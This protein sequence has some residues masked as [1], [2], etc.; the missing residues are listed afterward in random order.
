ML[1]SSSVAYFRFEGLVSKFAQV[2]VLHGFLWSLNALRRRPP[3]PLLI[4]R[5]AVCTAVGPEKL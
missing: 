2:K 5:L 3:L 1:S 4:T